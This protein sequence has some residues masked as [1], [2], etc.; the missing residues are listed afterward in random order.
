MS[1]GEYCGGNNHLFILTLNFWMT[2]QPTL[3]LCWARPVGEGDPGDR[4][5][6]AGA[7]RK[8]GWGGARTPAGKR[9]H[10]GSGWGRGVVDDAGGRLDMPQVPAPCVRVE[11]RV[12]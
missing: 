9:A 1:C 5:T 7:I 10:N 11:E 12:L 3:H 6:A 8:R 4:A 2:P